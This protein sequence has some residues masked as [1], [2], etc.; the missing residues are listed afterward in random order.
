M[1]HQDRL[2]EWTRMVSTNLPQLSKPQARVLALWS[3]GIVM[4]RSCG[5]TTVA[6]FLALL[7]GRKAATVAQQ[8]Q[9]WLL[10]AQAKAGAK[11]GIKR[12]TLD[13]SSCF[14]PLLAWVLRLWSGT[15]LA[16]AVDA[17]TLSDRFTLL[18]ISVVYRGCAIPVA[19]TVL[20]GGQKGAWRQAWLRMLRVLR[21]AVPP[22]LSVLVLAD[23]G[24]YARWLFRRIVRLGWHPFL[25]INGHTTFRPHGR[26]HF[27]RVRDLVPQVGRSWQGRGTAFKTPGSHLECTLTACWSEPH[28][29]PWCV[30]TDLV[31]EACQAVWYGLR[32]WCEQGFKCLKR[33][34]WFW[35]HTR[36]DDAERVA[37]L[38]LA[39]AVATMWMLS[40]GSEAEELLSEPELAPIYGLLQ[41]SVRR[42]RQRQ[43]R[44][45]RLGLLWL[46]VCVLHGRGVPLP[47][48]LKP[49]PWP[50]PAALPYLPPLLE[51]C[52]H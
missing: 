41:Q 32:S 6:A 44:V 36:M 28:A 46:L 17:S 5:R 48:R 33:G 8:L 29:E 4:T 31:S 35:Q 11:R 27:Y 15:T 23:R 37:R 10:P 38:G 25:R 19:W 49:E 39:L 14:A 40:V 21:P 13:V 52:A 20:P 51:D 30:L 2:S 34:A 47:K 43:V 26:A 9:E 45:L 24:L 42:P 16:L 50:Q 22:T 1:A 3:Y 12:A 7:L 18:V